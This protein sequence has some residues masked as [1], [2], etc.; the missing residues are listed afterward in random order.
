MNN[1]VTITIPTMVGKLLL[2][3]F[4]FIRKRRRLRDPSRDEFAW[5]RLWFF[6]GRQ[7]TLKTAWDQRLRV[8]LDSLGDMQAAFGREGEEGIPEILSALK[9][10]GVVLDIG[11]HIGGFSLIAARAVG[12]TGK[13]FAF[14]PVA[15]NVELLKENRRLN[16]ADWIV[17][18]CAAVG[19]KD[20]SIELFVSDTDTM[21]ATTRETWSNVLHHGTAPAHIKAKRVPLVTVDGFVR[22]NSIKN[23][24]L[25]KIDVEAAEMDVLAGAAETLTDGRIEQLLIEVH[26][27][28]VKWEH[29]AALLRGYGYEVAELSPGEMHALRR[30]PGAKTEGLSLID[31]RPVGV[32]LIGCGAVSEQHYSGALDA[33]ASEGLSE[34]L[35]IV[36]PQLERR[37]KLLEYFP[38]ARHYPDI[39]AMLK[40]VTPELAV[41]AAPHRFHADLSVQCLEKGIH[42]LC[43]KPMALTAQECDRMIK[44]AKH[45]EKLLA[46]GHFRRFY[47][48]CETIK[49]FLESGCL[50]RVKSFRFLEGYRY[51]WPVISR[52]MF[53]KT[54]AGGGVLIDTGVHALDLI[55][56]WLGDA[57]D[58]SYQDDAMGG[59]EANCLLR[60]SMVDGAEGVLRFSRDW[61]LPNCCTIE[62]EKGWLKYSCDITDR[63]NWG[64]Y[65]TEY[66]INAAM[67]KA[68]QADATGTFPLGSRASAHLGDYFTAQM[69]NVVEA[70]RGRASVRVPGTDA[71]KAIVLIE[72]CYRNRELLPMTWLGEAELR[73]ASELA[74]GH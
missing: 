4:I 52:S 37:L 10:G 42:V 23:I 11:A 46:V 58:V 64:F 18:I 9:P 15:N 70:A 13:V 2:K 51:S 38:T 6:K 48:S 60:L 35:A 5:G 20:G 65:G 45:A 27:P 30:R 1:L 24:A 19:R 40:D 8:R 14:E 57:A 41:I 32:A 44:A 17:P 7:V 47:S 72:K 63:I 43:E 28:A 22:E 54:S 29:V 25:I 69:R 49:K 67:H 16:G 26:G 36:D 55:L 53:D 62:C 59:V 68:I 34:T 71:R 33:V 12:D 31:R 39:E 21:W 56:W 66:S 74:S 50:G 73:Q 61:P 3:F